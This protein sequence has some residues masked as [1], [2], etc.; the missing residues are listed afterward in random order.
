[1]QKSGSVDPL[2]K[3]CMQSTTH[4]GIS[5]VSKQRGVGY[6]GEGRSSAPP[7]LKAAVVASVKRPSGVASCFLALRAFMLQKCI[8]KV[9]IRRMATISFLTKLLG[10][11]NNNKNASCLFCICWFQLGG[12][13]GG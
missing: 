6:G 9:C 2:L 4:H 13:G 11:H 7:A 8:V 5:Q 1:M 3:G 10:L 12:A